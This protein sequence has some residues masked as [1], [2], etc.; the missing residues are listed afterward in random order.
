[1]PLRLLSLWLLVACAGC[2]LTGLQS[3]EKQ[4]VLPDC[5][6]AADQY[7]Y[8]RMFQSAQIV[9]SDPKVK[10]EQLDRIMECHEKVVKNFPDD[11]VYTPM[12]YLEIADCVGSRGDYARAIKMYEAVLQKYPN[13]EYISARAMLSIGRTLD[14][15]SKFEEAKKVYHDI[16][17]RYGDTKSERVRAIVKVAQNSYYKVREANK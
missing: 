3:T 8:A 10:R 6:T 4:L 16:E 17:T 7:T 14:R 2:S 9:S 5:K 1:M 13:I 12:S 15:Q 11:T